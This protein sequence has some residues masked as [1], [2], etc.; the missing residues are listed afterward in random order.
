MK[1]EG[2][3][4]TVG[5]V[6]DYVRHVQRQPGMN[7]ESSRESRCLQM[8][9]LALEATICNGVCLAGPLHTS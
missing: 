3:R 6:Q 1:V 9:A 2:V 5:L 4:K 8:I 7:Q